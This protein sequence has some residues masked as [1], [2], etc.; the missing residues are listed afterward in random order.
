MPDDAWNRYLLAYHGEHPGITEDILSRA[1]DGH[2]HTAYQN[3]QRQIP[4]IA[5][6]V[7]DLACGSA[8]LANSLQ[9]RGCYVGVDVSRGELSAAAARIGGVFVE[10]DAMALPFADGTFDAVVC[11][12]ALMLLR[13]LP[14]AMTEIARVLRPGGVLAATYPTWGF[15][16]PGEAWHLLPIFARLRTLPEF[17]QTLTTARLKRA[18]PETGMALVSHHTSCYRIALTRP[19]DAELLING[20]YLPSVNEER[21][22]AATEHVAAMITRR[23]VTVP[24]HI[25]HLSMIR[26]SSIRAA[27]RR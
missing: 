2:G 3:L 7:L 18:G 6:C 15:M 1:R 8:P 9:L 22:R 14:S 21:M 12:M 26:Q 20:L 19:A 13:P 23:P 27:T 17:P 11:S 4:P 25:A 10:A 16:R 5:T 24:I